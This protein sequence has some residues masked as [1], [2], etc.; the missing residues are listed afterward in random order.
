MSVAVR[1]FFTLGNTKQIAEALAEGAEERRYRCRGGTLLCAYAQYQ[2]TQGS[3]EGIR[4]EVFR[5]IPF[6]RNKAADGSR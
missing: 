5:L 1:Y 2:G 3:R 4:K 6:E